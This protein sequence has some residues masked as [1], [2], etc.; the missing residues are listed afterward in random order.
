VDA[1]IQELSRIKLEHIRAISPN[2][3]ISQAPY[4]HVLRGVVEFLR[5][6]GPQPI[7]SDRIERVLGRPVEVIGRFTQALPNNWKLY[8]ENVK[9]TYL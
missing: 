4:G 2:Q 9:D 3:K 8:Y 7:R 5:R 6:R 1:Q